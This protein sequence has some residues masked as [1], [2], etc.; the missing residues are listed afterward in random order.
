MRP[1]SCDRR[2]EHVGVGVDELVDGAPAQHLARPR[3]ARSASSPSTSASTA[4]PGTCVRLLHRQP[5]LLEQHRCPAACAI[6][7]LNRRPAERCRSR[8][9]APCA[10]PSC[11]SP[12][13]SSTVVIDRHD[14][15]ELH[16]AEHERVSGMIH[17]L[18]ARPVCPSAAHPRLQAPATRRPPHPRCDKPTLQR[19]PP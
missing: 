12:I 10:R 14:P 18:R 19:D 16:R 9:G 4:V 5:E 7:G 6:P 2:H 15:G 1:S 17:P 3:G 8:P 13:R 11:A